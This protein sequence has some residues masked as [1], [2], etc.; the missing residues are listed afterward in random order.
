VPQPP[1]LTD[2]QAGSSYIRF[3]HSD[4]RCCSSSIP[5]CSSRSSVITSKFALRHCLSNGNNYYI[6][7]FYII[8]TILLT[9]I[10]IIVD[11]QLSWFVHTPTCAH[12]LLQISTAMSADLNTVV[13]VNGLNDCVAQPPK[14]DA[15]SA[16]ACSEQPSLNGV[17]YASSSS[18]VESVV[19]SEKG[20][21]V[22]A[23]ARSIT[24]SMIDD[25]PAASSPSRSCTSRWNSSRSSTSHS[26]QRRL[27]LDAQALGVHA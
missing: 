14:S 19:S 9:L 11:R 13:P 6:N 18:N 7:I 5:V 27:T 12:Y 1:A 22:F 26:T 8:A 3:V 20:D 25:V 24:P 15:G 10:I 21:D 16:V 17:A 4:R 2:G 23:N